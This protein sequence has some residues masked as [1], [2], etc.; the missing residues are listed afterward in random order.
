MGKAKWFIYILHCA[1]ESLYTGIALDIPKRI[2]AHSSGKGSRCVRGK[3]PVSLVYQESRAD[4]S[5]ALK[6]EA[7][8]K[9][10]THGEKEALILRRR[11][12]KNV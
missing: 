4:R 5:A 12:K 1:D 6:R 2:A 3:L 10:L 7:Q 11:L 9:R 8:I